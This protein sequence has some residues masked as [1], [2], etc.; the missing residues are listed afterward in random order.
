MAL[1]LSDD[2]WVVANFKETQLEL[3]RVGQP[4]DI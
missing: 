4:V 1:S 3:M 2:I